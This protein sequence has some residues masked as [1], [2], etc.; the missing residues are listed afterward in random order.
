MSLWFILALMTA[1]A[2]FSVLWP[3]GRGIRPAAGGSEVAVYKDQLA[4]VTRDVAAGLIGSAEADAAR[5]EIGR[6]LLAAADQESLQTSTSSAGYRRAISIVALVG[7]P[8]VA[9]VLYARLGSPDLPDFPLAART[10]PSSP[11]AASLERLIEKVQTILERNPADGRG[12]AVLAPVLFK[13]GRYDEAVQAYRKALAYDGENAARHSDLGEAVTAAANGVVTADAKTEFD[14]AIA[15]D[16]DDVK[17]RY[18]VGLAA[19]QDGQTAKA[20]DLWRAML[21]SAPAN[22]SWKPVVQESLA[23]V[24]GVR[25]PQLSDEQMSSVEGMGAADRGAM[26][27]SMVDRL[28]TRLKSNTDDVEGWLRLTRAYMVLGE[29]DKAAAARHE[30]QQALIKNPERLRQL[31][32]G[33]KDMGFDG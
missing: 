24:S 17:A 18:F 20:A 26:I 30:A 16:P 27:R 22:A 15:L 33:L 8:L 31:N 1:A 2:V 3:L 9:L 11:E 14:R 10:Q 6:R 32:D 21:A 29:K 13:V 7:L 28:A 25:A 23:R 4:E 19:E 5:I 12:W